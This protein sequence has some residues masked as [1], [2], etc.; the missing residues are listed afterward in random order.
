M[1]DDTTPYSL[2]IKQIEEQYEYFGRKWV[3]FT[4]IDRNAYRHGIDNRGLLDQIDKG[5][6]GLVYVTGRHLHGVIELLQR[7]RLK[8]PHAI[9]SNVGT[10]LYFLKP[11]SAN[12]L[13]SELTCNDF[14]E[15]EEFVRK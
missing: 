14:I 12:K 10:R 11:E 8:K 1:D 2:L 15:D 4:D 6:W 3:L 5:K 13:E 9:A 7:G